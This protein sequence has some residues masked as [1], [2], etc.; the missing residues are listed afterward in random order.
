MARRH[1]VSVR[2]RIKIGATVN[3]PGSGI[4]RSGLQQGVRVRVRV[5]D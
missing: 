2:V 4:K 1:K 3:G 5:R